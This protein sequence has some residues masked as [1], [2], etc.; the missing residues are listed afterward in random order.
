[1]SATE[2]DRRTREAID[3]AKDQLSHGWTPAVVVVVLADAAT[4]IDAIRAE[5]AVVVCDY[6]HE[7]FTGTPTRDPVTVSWL[8]D[9]AQTYCSQAHLEAAQERAFDAAGGQP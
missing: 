9:G 8:G 7:E 4:V 6:D 5:Q 3:E 1:M 2:V